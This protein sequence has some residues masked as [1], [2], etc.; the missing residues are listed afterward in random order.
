MAGRGSNVRAALSREQLE[1]RRKM[2]IMSGLEA[3]LI[4]SVGTAVVLLGVSYFA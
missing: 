3:M 1:A 4:V 2:T